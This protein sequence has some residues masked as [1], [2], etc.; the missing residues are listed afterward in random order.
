MLLGQPIHDFA[1]GRVTQY[2]LLLRL[3]M[4]DG[5]LALPGEFLPVAEHFGS[6]REIDSWVLRAAVDLLESRPDLE[7]LHVNVSTASLADESFGA[8]LKDVLN[9]SAVDP[10][11]LILEITETA[12]ISHMDRAS[13]LAAQVQASGHGL[14]LDDFGS[15]FAS[16]YYL[17][18][19]PVDLLKIDGEFVKDLTSS[20]L[21]RT[22]VQAIVQVARSLGRRTVAECVED[23]AALGLLR[24][25]G[26][27]AAQGWHVGRPAPLPAAPN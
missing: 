18:H 27:D 10:R 15:G 9:R 19:L 21:S 17:K 5:S 25:M 4:D 22:V 6:I 14:A 20:D 7:L 13:A 3:R 11:R 12:A 1:E 2:E 23:G 16:F 24:E 8:E 26:V